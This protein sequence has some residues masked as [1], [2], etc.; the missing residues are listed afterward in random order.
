MQATHAAA[1]SLVL[2]SAAVGLLSLPATSA[3]STN[4]LGCTVN[5]T[6]V[7]TSVT[8]VYSTGISSFEK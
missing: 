2:I 6:C 4:V 8:E 3:Q 7:G 1:A 5:G